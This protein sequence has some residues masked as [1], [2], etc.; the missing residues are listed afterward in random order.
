MRLKFMKIVVGKR[1]FLIK[2]AKALYMTF[3]YIC[4]MLVSNS[5]TL[6]LLAKVGVLNLFLDEVQQIVIP[7]QVEREIAQK[8]DFDFFVI[9][10][11]IMGKRILL[12]KVMKSFRVMQEQFKL[13]EGEAAAYMLCMQEHYDGVMT[14]DRE[15]I[16]LCKLE[17]LRF[18]CAAAIIV[19]LFKNKRIKCEETLLMLDKLE[20]YGRYSQDILT[21]FRKEVQ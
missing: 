3:V 9:Q 15:L 8:K 12:Q 20:I 1:L 2:R 14:D 13:D 4:I 10:K 11:E 7:L 21:Y 19:Q 6:I 17:G 18:F 16:K 5:S